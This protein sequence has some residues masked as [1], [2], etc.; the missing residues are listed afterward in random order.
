MRLSMVDKKEL[1]QKIVDE[2]ENT[3]KLRDSNGILNDECDYLVGAIT[4]MK[5]INIELWNSSEDKSLG[6]VPPIW[7]FGPMSGRSVLNERKK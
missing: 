2:V 3:L 1:C 7:I 5:V 6:V 4:V